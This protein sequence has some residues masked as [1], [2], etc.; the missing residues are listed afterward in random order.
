MIQLVGGKTEGAAPQQNESGYAKPAAS[1]ENTQPT[2]AASDIKEPIDD[3][4]F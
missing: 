3:L 4:P 1:Y 2:I